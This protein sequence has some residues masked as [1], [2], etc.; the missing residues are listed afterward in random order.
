MPVR[1]LMASVAEIDGLKELWGET[2][3]DARITVVILDGPVDQ[4]NPCFVGVR[5]DTFP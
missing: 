5:P 4:L 3:G 2:I 1:V